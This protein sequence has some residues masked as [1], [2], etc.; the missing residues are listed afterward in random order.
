MAALLAPAQGGWQRAYRQKEGQGHHQAVTRSCH[1]LGVSSS[2][3]LLARRWWCVVVVV[4]V[5][6]LC[7][8]VVL[9]RGVGTPL[10]KQRTQ[11]FV[12]HSN[13]AGGPPEQWFGEPYNTIH[14]NIQNVIVIHSCNGN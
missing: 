5:W 11:R 6:S 3:L 2:L 7:V 14:S 12:C 13:G 9:C 1:L 10:K 4:V 8:G